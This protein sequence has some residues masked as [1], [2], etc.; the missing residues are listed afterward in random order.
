MPIMDRFE[1]AE[2][3]ATKRQELRQL[4]LVNRRDVVLPDNFVENVAVNRG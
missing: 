2:Y 3:G 1:V 4:A